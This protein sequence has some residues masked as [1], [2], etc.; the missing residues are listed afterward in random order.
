MERTKKHVAVAKPSTLEKAINTAQI[1]AAYH[2]D[3][4]VNNKFIRNKG[5]HLGTKYVYCFNCG[6][7]G[8]YARNCNASIIDA[9]RSFVFSGN[10]NPHKF[11]SYYS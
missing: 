8:H 6:Q 4:K 3:D 7:K 5:I 10:T 11:V 2:Y 9:N 1:F